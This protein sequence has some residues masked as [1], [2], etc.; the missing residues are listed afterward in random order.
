LMDMVGNPAAAANLIAEIDALLDA[1]DS[2][3]DAHLSDGSIGV[4]FE[5]PE[6]ARSF[7]RQFRSLLTG[8]RSPIS[9][10]MV[11]PEGGANGKQPSG[12]EANPSSGAAA[13]RRSP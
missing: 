6:Q 2:V 10:E 12:S 5:S 4:K 9:S 3:S 1:H 13:S 11:E 7:L 8:E